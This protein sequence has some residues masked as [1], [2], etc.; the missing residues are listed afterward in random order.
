MLERLVSNQNMKCMV[1]L[2]LNKIT[3]HYTKNTPESRKVS[4]C[5]VNTT[6]YHL[7]VLLQLHEADL[8]SLFSNSCKVKITTLKWCKCK[9]GVTAVVPSFVT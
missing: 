6:K 1:I 4:K 9:F 5:Q 8:S 7:H 3:Y 2:L